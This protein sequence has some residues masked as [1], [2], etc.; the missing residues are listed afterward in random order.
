[1]GEFSLYDIVG[2]CILIAMINIPWFVHV[3]MVVSDGKCTEWR[4]ASFRTFL[5]EFKR[6]YWDHRDPRWPRSFFRDSRNSEIHAG[7]IRFRGR[8]MVI[9]PWDY[10]LLSLFLFLSRYKEKRK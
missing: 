10:W 5:K 4:F 8:G 1:M 3:T 6:T 9:Y 7:M 2:L